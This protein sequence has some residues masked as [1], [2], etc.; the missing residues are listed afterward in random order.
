MAASTKSGWFA[1]IIGQRQQGARTRC[2]TR[3][4]SMSEGGTRAPLRMG[5]QSV[6]HEGEYYRNELPVMLSHCSPFPLAKLIGIPV[7][8]EY[9]IVR[10]LNVLDE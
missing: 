4:L 5:L 6:E 3:C 8:L 7:I 2:V 9:C 1:S 10:L